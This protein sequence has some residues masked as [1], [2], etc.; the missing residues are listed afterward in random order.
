VADDESDL[1]F[2]LSVEAGI[3]GAGGSVVSGGLPGPQ[4]S[5]LEYVRR[6]DGLCP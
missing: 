4:E 6:D 3:G 1:F 2:E 5:H